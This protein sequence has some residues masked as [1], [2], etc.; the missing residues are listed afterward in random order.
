MSAQGEPGALGVPCPKCKA[1]LGERC[2]TASGVPAT[3][4]HVPRFDLWMDTVHTE[5][6]A[7][8]EWPPVV[9]G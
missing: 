7:P 4:V 6:P 3:Y 5:P 8:A 2:R 1:T 9:L